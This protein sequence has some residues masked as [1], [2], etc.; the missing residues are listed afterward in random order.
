VLH[1]ALDELPRGGAQQVHQGDLAA[2]AEMQT[3]GAR[4]ITARTKSMMRRL[5][6]QWR[7]KCVEP[8]VFHL[9]ERVQRVLHRHDS[10]VDNRRAA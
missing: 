5:L 4:P 6:K 7:S 8:A 9:V 1:V 3:G 2:E 10:T